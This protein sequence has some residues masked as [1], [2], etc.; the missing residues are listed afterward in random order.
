MPSTPTTRPIHRPGI[1]DHPS[2][3]YARTR[4]P[5]LNLRHALRS[6]LRMRRKRHGAAQHLPPRSDD[7]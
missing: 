6:I 2:A 7:N 3:R 1:P 5:A 4:S